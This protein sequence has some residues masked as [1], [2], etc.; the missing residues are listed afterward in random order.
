MKLADKLVIA[1][2]RTA[3]SYSEAVHALLTVGGATVRRGL[4]GEE[5]GGVGEGT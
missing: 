1:T 4:P 2:Q 5:S 3:G